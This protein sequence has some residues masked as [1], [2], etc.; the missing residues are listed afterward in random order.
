ME[1]WREGE[2]KDLRE[3]FK[4][5]EIE[6]SMPETRF[7]L[8]ARMVHLAPAAKCSNYNLFSFFL[9]VQICGNLYQI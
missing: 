3:E 8:V 4:K 9:Q 5:H 7:G 1:I 6:D 2:E